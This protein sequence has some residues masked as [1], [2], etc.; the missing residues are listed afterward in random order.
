MYQLEKSQKMLKSN[1]HNSNRIDN[2]SRKNRVN[3]ARAGEYTSEK[4]HESKSFLTDDEMQKKSMNLLKITNNTSKFLS[5][6]TLNS[7]DHSSNLSSLGVT[8]DSQMVPAD[9]VKNLIKKLKKDKLNRKKCLINYQQKLHK[10][11]EKEKELEE[12]NAKQAAREKEEIALKKHQE[13]IKKLKLNQEER[14]KRKKEWLEIDKMGIAKWRIKNS[15]NSED[16]RKFMSKVSSKDADDMELAYTH[17]RY[18]KSFDADIN[19]AKE[20]EYSEM[21][22]NRE[23]MLKPLDAK[24]IKKFSKDYD[25]LRKDLVE[26][27]KKQRLKSEIIH[28]YKPP[29]FTKIAQNCFKEEYEKSKNEE[30]KSQTRKEMIKKRDKY[31]QLVRDLHAPQVN[32]VKKEE[33]KNLISKVSNHRVEKLDKR[34]R[35]NVSVKNE[36]EKSKGLKKNF[37]SNAF[38]KNQVGGNSTSNLQNPIKNFRRR[39]PKR[40]SPHSFSAQKEAL[41]SEIPKSFDYLKHRRNIREQSGDGFPTKA[42]QYID[43]AKQIE[44]QNSQVL[45]NMARICESEAK[46]KEQLLDVQNSITV[47]NSKQINKMY[48]NS[49]KAKLAYIHQMQLKSEALHYKFYSNLTHKPILMTSV[50]TQPLPLFPFPKLPSKLQNA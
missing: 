28:D 25:V 9:E 21:K 4:L 35:H 31:W 41:K 3:L 42:V 17:V 36:S 50:P 49:I 26:R 27:K 18:Q 10:I 11:Q 15:A 23:I 13:N 33:M 20:L 30:L 22:K 32:E 24:G 6:V 45:V 12:E 5:G 47:D 19:K 16:E 46:R 38:P 29:K 8:K 37:S 44:E 48:V 40:N 7:N 2:I 14:A 43:R 34:D 1:C 39:Q